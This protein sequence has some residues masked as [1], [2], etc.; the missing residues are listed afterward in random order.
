MRMNVV[1]FIC[2][3]C[4]YKHF[5][6]KVVPGGESHMGGYRISARGY[7][8]FKIQ[9]IINMYIK[10][11]KRY[12]NYENRN[13]FLFPQNPL[14]PTMEGHCHE[15]LLVTGRGKMVSVKNVAPPLS[16]KLIRF[17]WAFVSAEGGFV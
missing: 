1:S 2:Y 16:W 3:I 5:I 17:C 14:Y 11:Q 6:F 9:K 7:R 13:H 4:F 15:F 10:V 8:H 12:K